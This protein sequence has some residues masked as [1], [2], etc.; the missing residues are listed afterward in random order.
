ML[1]IHRSNCV[2]SP[3][4]LQITLKNNFEFNFWGTQVLYRHYTASQFLASASLDHAS[5]NAAL[6]DNGVLQRTRLQRE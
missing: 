2:T 1:S 4:T 3:A 5:F 6:E